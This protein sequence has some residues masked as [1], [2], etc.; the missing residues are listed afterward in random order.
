MVGNVMIDTLTALLPQIRARGMAAELG[1]PV[2]DYGVVTLHRPSNVDDPVMLERWVCTLEE[3]AGQTTLVFPAHPRTSGRLR[4]AGL[5]DRLGAAGVRVIEPQPYVEF[6]SLVADAR[7]VLTDSGGIQEETTVLGIPCLT[8]RD[9]TE[10]PVTVTHGTNRLV[11]ADPRAAVTAAGEVLAGPPAGRGL[12]PMWDGH[13]ADRIVAILD[14]L[15][16][17]ACGSPV[18]GAVAGR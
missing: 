2:G 17:R 18:Q 15:E 3:I 7:I 16:W 4:Q 10:R 6:V 9:S 11:G 8:L 12:P 13:A 14:R 1:L 5:I